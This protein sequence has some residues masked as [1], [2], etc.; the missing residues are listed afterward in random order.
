MEK[1]LKNMILNQFTFEK[2]EKIIFFC[3]ENKVFEFIA[4]ILE[5]ENLEDRI[6]KS[7]KDFKELEQFLQSFEKELNKFS[8]RQII[9]D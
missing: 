6:L 8:M 1:D 2:A 7:F 3:E 4:D 5:E 9:N